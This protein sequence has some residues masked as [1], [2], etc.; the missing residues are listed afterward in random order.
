MGT[1]RT[2]QGSKLSRRGKMAAVSKTVT[3]PG[4][5]DK[6]PVVA[7]GTWTVWQSKPG[8]VCRCVKDAI[9]AGY[10]HIDCAWV[11]ANEEEVGQ[12][13]KEK[14]ADGTIKREDVFVTTK[15]WDTFHG[16]A[17]AKLGLQDSLDKLGLDYVD[18]ALI[19]WPFAFKDGTDAFP[20]GED[21]KIILAHHD[22]LDTWK[23]LEDCHSAGMARNIGISNFNSEQ[24]K[25]VLNVATVKPCN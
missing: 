24:I 8:E 21:G 18:L 25:R 3:L 12:A 16:R 2:G 19:H 1:V 14:I 4:S 10:R 11:Y 7:Y 13:I 15:V 20:K 23:G 6:M 22:L 9:D 5:G 17:R